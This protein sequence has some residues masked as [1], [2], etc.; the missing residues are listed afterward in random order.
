MRGR[1]SLGKRCNWGKEEREERE[2]DCGQEGKLFSAINLALNCFC[3]CGPPT[4][5]ICTL[6][7]SIARETP[8]ATSH[9]KYF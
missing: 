7:L 1:G 4:H 9:L 5:L 2:R 3:P 8:P 6:S